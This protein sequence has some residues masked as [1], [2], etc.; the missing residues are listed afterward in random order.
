[1]R[2]LYSFLLY[3]ALPFIFLRLLWRSRHLSD[4][5]KR[6]GERLGFYPNKFEHCIWVHAVSVG[7]TIAAIPLIKSL[8]Q[9]YPNLPVLVTTMTPTGAARVQAAFGDR[10]T[11]A[12]IPYDFPGAVRRFLN[13]MNPK[14][15]VIMETELWPNLFAQCYA[16]NIPVCVMNARLSAKS[17]RG[18]ARVGALA[19]ELLQKVTVIAAH[20][21][22]DAERFIELGAPRECVVVTGSIKFDLEIPEDLYARA[23][24]L[25]ERLGRDRF[26]WVAA[27]THEGEEEQLLAAHAQIR[28]QDPTALLVLVPRHPDRF[29][30]VA[31]LCQKSVVLQRHSS[32]QTCTPEVAV[33]LGDTMGELMLMYAASDAAFVGG[34]LIPRGGH[35]LLEPAALCKPVL[36][37]T[38][39]FNFAE[40]SQLLISADALVLVAGPDVLAHQL[41]RLIQ[42]TNE[43]AALGQRAEQVVKANRGAL[44]K[45]LGL[46]DKYLQQ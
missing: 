4:Y 40:I 39:L 41:A 32:Q 45:Q 36:S 6:W 21:H 44:A 42:D 1:M 35:N 29:D 31:D 8:L 10:V 20:G 15:A 17:A 9:R 14:I 12:Y 3:L 27:S 23:D 46:I 11:H 24:S 26:V 22:D 2:Y 28:A 34:S 43:R 7:E 5:R 18:Y 37:G 38:H 25:R 19:R 33:Y 30:A 16:R 13:A